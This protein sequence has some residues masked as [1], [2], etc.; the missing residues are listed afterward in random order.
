MTAKTVQHE[1]N[2]K[3]SYEKGR[4]LLNYFF[5]WVL[6]QAWRNLA[7]MRHGVIRNRSTKR[8]KPTGNLFRKNLELKGVC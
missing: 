1:N 2:C 3:F 8:L 4:P 7:T 5:N 6:L